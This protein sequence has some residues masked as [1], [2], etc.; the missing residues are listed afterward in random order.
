MHS[1]LDLGVLR[2]LFREEARDLLQ[3]CDATHCIMGWSE[4]LAEWHHSDSKVAVHLQDRLEDLVNLNASMGQHLQD[5]FVA[6]DFANFR[7]SM[8]DCS[9]ILDDLL[10]S[11]SEGRRPVFFE[12]IEQAVEAAVSKTMSGLSTELMSATQ[13]WHK[14]GEEQCQRGLND[15]RRWADIDVRMQKLEERTL[16]VAEE[17]ACQDANTQARFEGV[18]T[19]V[20]ERTEFTMGWV[21][22]DLSASLQ[23]ATETMIASLRKTTVQDLFSIKQHFDRRIIGATPDGAEEEHL[24]ALMK[25]FASQLEN[26]VSSHQS[27]ERWRHELQVLKNEHGNMVSAS[28]QGKSERE[29]LGNVIRER[30]LQLEKLAADLATTKQALNA[31]VA[32]VTLQ[33]QVDRVQAKKNISLDMVAGEIDILTGMDFTSV[34]PSDPPIAEFRSEEAADKALADMAVLLYTFRDVQVCIESHMKAAKGATAFWDSLVANRADL[35]KE[36]LKKLGVNTAMIS[37]IGLRGD[38]GLNRN[39]IRL[40]VNLFPGSISAPPTSSPPN[41]KK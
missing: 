36:R 20:T 7:D 41:A 37:T 21:T 40:K 26:G 29:D 14:L 39:C 32:W 15:D 35:V 6:E 3:S 22:K 1:E 5:T 31:P 38:K 17:V 19:Q 8:S 13:V 18:K 11:R 28:Q 23:R 4:Q 30:D 27:A 33:K 12:S 10:T 2:R 34:N 9:R 24:H 16:R 25:K